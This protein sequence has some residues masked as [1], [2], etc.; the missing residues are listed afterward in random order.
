MRE[1]FGACASAGES[2]AGDGGQ[3]VAIAGVDG[4]DVLR[5]QIPGGDA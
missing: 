1:I 4:A 5:G 3:V 2:Q